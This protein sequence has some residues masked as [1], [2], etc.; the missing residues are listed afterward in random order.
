MYYDEKYVYSENFSP[1]IIL[2]NTPRISRI[3]DSMFGTKYQTKN[4]LVN[5]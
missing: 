3:T 1:T 2:L 5:R 4:K